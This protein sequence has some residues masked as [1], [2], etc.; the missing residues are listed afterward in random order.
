M[1]K[2]VTQRVAYLSFSQPDWFIPQNERFWL[3]ITTKNSE[4]KNPESSDA[5]VKVNVYSRKYN[6][7]CLGTANIQAGL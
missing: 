1:T 5:T 6:F 3:A 7:N 2:I 4:H